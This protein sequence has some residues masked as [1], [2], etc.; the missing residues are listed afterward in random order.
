M[1]IRAMALVSTILVPFAA[2]PALA[3]DGD[4]NNGGTG[5]S[6]DIVVRAPRVEEMAR[7][8]QKIAPN[9]IN[10]QSAE[11]IA[12]Y[13]D[14]NAAEALARIPGI[15]LSSDTGEGRFVNIR[16]IDGNL[17]GATYGG[18]VLL[19]TNP[20]GTVFGSGRAVEFDTI[21]T[22][23][24]DGI[25]VYKT[26]LPNHD[27]EGLGGSVELTPRSAAHLTK[28]FIEGAIG[29][30]YEPA[31]KHGGPLN[32]DLGVGGR[33]GPDDKPF[34]FVL[35]G[36]F[37]EDR[38]GF[39][40]I[41]ADYID[42]K[43]LTS[44]SGPAFS[45]LQVDKALADIQLRR[46]DY[47]R[48]RFGYGGE[49]AYTPSDDHQYYIRASIAGYVESVLK[50]RL[51]YDKL[52]GSA[53]SVD[54]ANPAGYATTTKI[55]IK[56]TDEEETHLNEVF[57]LGGRDKFG[58]LS[59]DYRG[60]YSRATFKVSRNFGTTYT[61]PSNV[62]F[63]YDNI[64]NSEFPSLGITGGAVNVNDPAIYQLTKL[65]NAQE[66]AVDREWS[67]AINA[68][69][70]TNWLG[71]DDHFQFGGEV[72]LRNKVDTPAAQSYDLPDSGLPA[73]TGAIT[74]FYANHYSNGP[75]VNP[76]A[77]RQLAGQASTTGLA[78][79][80]TGY[81]A[82]EEDIY[83]GYAMYTAS[84]G[85][86]GV[87]AGVRVEHTKA[88]YSSYAFDQDDNNLGLVVR[89][90]SYTN[91][92]P[93]LQL[94]YDVTPTFVARATYSSAIGRPGFSQI[95]KPITI[96]RDNEIETTGNPD[97]KPTI[98]HNFD[99]S[100]EYYLPHAGII[101]LGFFDKEFSDYVVART[102]NG[103]DPINLPDASV[104]QFVTYENV[105]SAHAR[106]VEAAYDQRFAFL[107]KPFDGLGIGGNVTYV[108]S[109]VELRL[110]E[111]R[112]LPATSKWTWNA[113]AY[114]EAHGVQLRLAAQYVGKNLFGIGD[115]ADFDVFQSARTTLD[116]T[117]SLDIY[118]GVRLYFNVKNLTNEPLRIYERSENRPIQREFY[119][120]TFEGGLK[121][122]F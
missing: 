44:A 117:S 68:T 38:R 34:S 95:A 32:L 61:G 39:D 73:L 19:N 103:T 63:T 15:S 81:F 86:L 116:L 80:L 31:H 22:G 65:S 12:K 90:R 96:D 110:G 87:L 17:N 53:L 2:A 57:V 114:Y 54:P 64:T 37:R 101:S 118:K 112:A 79:D 108:D 7:E 82:A 55:T 121:F 69:L 16:G 70:A 29:Y 88:T 106:G 78:D 40:D 42:D 50:N 14:F 91:A 76:T 105:S 119:D 1:K 28:P 20:G 72:R 97:L 66:R 107:P 49:L 51:T 92:F 98:G 36:S 27:A 93:T 23:A 109:E 11:A 30:G 111:K 10:V 122:K 46:Y 58:A 60:S 56:G 99:L 45:A 62:P 25:V 120:R 52:D 4:S 102:R 74:D 18:V 47:H 26:G 84:L 71:Q 75:Q 24:I 104:V 115:S 8:A 6:Q 113:A 100:L 13:P 83:A 3:A 5:P 43:S 59:L 48:R 94:K 89:K 9:L 41:E 33:F 35:T 21:P 77:I 67:G 85:K